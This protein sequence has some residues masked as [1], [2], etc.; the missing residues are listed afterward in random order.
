MTPKDQAL[1]LAQQIKDM[2]ASDDDRY[3]IAVIL[4]STGLGVAGA[5]IKS[6]KIVPMRA[7]LLLDEVQEWTGK[8]RN[9]IT[10]H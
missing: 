1:K 8:I 4:I 2:H 10:P 9:A 7:L 3:A 6:G 5:L